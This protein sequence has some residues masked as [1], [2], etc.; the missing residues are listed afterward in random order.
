MPKCA[1]VC[2]FLGLSKASSIYCL[3]SGL[4]ISGAVIDSHVR[5]QTDK[6]LLESKGDFCVCVCM[7]ERERKKEHTCVRGFYESGT[8]ASMPR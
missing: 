8:N 2:P 3:I 1:H 6:R 5:K 4:F 7:R